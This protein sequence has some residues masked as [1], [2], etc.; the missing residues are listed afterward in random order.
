MPRPAKGTILEHATKD[1]RVT[2]TLRFHVNGER[3]RVPLGVVSR[4]EAERQL[5]YAMADVARGEW[6]PPRPTPE[7]PG[8]VPTFHEYAD[9]WWELRKPDLAENT[10]LD[11]RWR[12]E[13]HLIDYFGEMPLSDITPT[14]VKGYIADKQ[15]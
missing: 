8:D 1:G 5:A 15:R 13:V 7:S 9:D 2:R 4:E 14:T 11:Y 10:R 6:K 12:L 3:R